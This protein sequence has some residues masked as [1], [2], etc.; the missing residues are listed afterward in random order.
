MRCRA[1]GI[2]SEIAGKLKPCNSENKPVESGKFIVQ[3]ICRNMEKD[4]NSTR[5]PEK[6]FPEI[7]V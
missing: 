4:Y 6:V 7:L 5:Q 1:P 2:Y 3:Q